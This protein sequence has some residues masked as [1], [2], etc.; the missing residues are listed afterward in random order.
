M[1][2]KM[3]IIVILSV[4]LYPAKSNAY[5]IIDGTSDFI[6]Y[7]TYK[8]KCEEASRYSS[9]DDEGSCKKAIFYL[10]KIGF[11]TTR[12]LLSDD[13]VKQDRDSISR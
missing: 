10:F 7:L 12:E 2:K 8:D 3:L 4:T 9:D 11:R 6:S 13:E 1:C 5:D